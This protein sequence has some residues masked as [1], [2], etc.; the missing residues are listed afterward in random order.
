MGGSQLIEASAIADKIRELTWARG[1]DKT[2][3]PSEVARDLAPENWRELMP[4][5]RETAATLVD[6]GEMAVAQKG[7]IVD[8]REAKGPI[9]L[10][11][12]AASVR[13]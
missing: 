4:A 11:S 10:R 3:C 6:A 9:R 5:V 1:P 2:I 7:R 13:R 12:T 8:P